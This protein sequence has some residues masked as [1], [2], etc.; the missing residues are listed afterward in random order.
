MFRERRLMFILPR[1]AY[2]LEAAYAASFIRRFSSPRR[3]LPGFLPPPARPRR[4][5]R[6]TPPCFTPDFLPYATR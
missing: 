3:L 5:R 4:R 6:D 2:F 1:Y